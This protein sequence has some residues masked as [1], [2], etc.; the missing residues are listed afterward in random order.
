MSFT[1]A[2]AALAVSCFL[3]GIVVGF[4]A[5]YFWDHYCTKIEEGTDEIE[6]DND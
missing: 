5:K 1:Q 3:L 4:S 2:V 6:D